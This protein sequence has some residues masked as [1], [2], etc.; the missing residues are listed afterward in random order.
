MTGLKMTRP[1][2]SRTGCA[3]LALVLLAGVASAEAP[4]QE[5][6]THMSEA[7][8]DSITRVVI[9][10]T[11]GAGSESVT[12]TYGQKTPGLAGGMA[13]GAEIGQVPVEVGHVPIVIPIPILRELGMLVGGITGSAQRI[14]QEMRDRMADD[15]SDAVE[16]P[17]TNNAL[18]N[19]VYWGL[20]NVSSVDPKLFAE[21][22]PI[23]ADT[24][25][26][27]YVHLN[28]IALNVQE[29]EA[30]VSTTATAR[31]QRY[32]DGAT[33]YRREV[34]YEDRDDL[35][36]WAK[37]DFVLWSEYKTFARHYIG[38]ELSAELY[39]RVALDHALAPADMPSV[40]PDKKKPWHGKTKTLTPT[41][42]WTFE[43]RGDDKAAADDATVLWDLEVYDTRQPV[44]SAKRIAGTQHT[45]DVPL[46]A[47]KTYRWSVRPSY[48]REDGRIN[49]EWMRRPVQG[50]S[51]NGNVGRAISEA[52]A[53][54]QDFPSFEVDCKAGRR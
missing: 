21:T 9:L 1:E 18:A 51:G 7:L 38:R 19:D 37:D 5:S 13:K 22:T 33:L 25:A 14:R 20:R 10:P 36:N 42:A 6:A 27:L 3:G 41:L 39:E 31:L 46:E 30:I 4:L 47:C 45:L 23:P 52:H 34:T 15:L 32:S 24:D 44:Y 49:G 16:Q 35:K 54:I 8:R 40:K 50:G 2:A 29:D 48:H 12:G 11:E 17:L 26:I 43:L 53:Y 28:E